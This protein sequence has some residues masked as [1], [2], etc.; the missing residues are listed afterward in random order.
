VYFGSPHARGTNP[1]L[2]VFRV[3]NP[4]YIGVKLV[5]VNAEV[6]PDTLSATYTPNANVDFLPYQQYCHWQRVDFQCQLAGA[7]QHE[8]HVP[9]RARLLSIKRPELCYHNRYRL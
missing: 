7:R 5:H 4:N 6:S 8:L 9:F 1:D 3:L 2:V